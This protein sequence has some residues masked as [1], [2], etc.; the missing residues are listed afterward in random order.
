MDYFILLLAIVAFAQGLP[1]LISPDS[2]R[3]RAKRIMK[4][5]DNVHRV[6]GLLV[7]V[8]ALFIVYLAL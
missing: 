6:N 1:S 2:V 5:S 8:I 4:A 3:A 7:S